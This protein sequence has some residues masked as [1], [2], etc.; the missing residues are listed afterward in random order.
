MMLQY[1]THTI[2]RATETHSIDTKWHLYELIDASLVLG[3]K[4]MDDGVLWW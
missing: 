2:Y 3:M 1:G 4:M